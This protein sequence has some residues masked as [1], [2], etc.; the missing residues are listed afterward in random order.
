MNIYITNICNQRCPYCYAEG[1]MSKDVKK[2][3]M[4]FRDFKKVLSLL[5]RSHNNHCRFEGGEPTI[6]PEFVRFLNHAIDQGFLIQLFTNGLF[7]KTVLKALIKGGKKVYYTWNINHPSLYSKERWNLVE[8]NLA[9]ISPLKT[10]V[11]GVN[12]YRPDQNFEFIS[13]LLKK[14]GIKRLR[15]CF[16]H[17]GEIDKGIECMSTATAGRVIPRLAKFMRSLGRRGVDCGF[18]CGLIPC[19]WKD[20]DIGYFV[21]HGFHLGTCEPCPGITTDLR[22]VHCFQTSDLSHA[23]PLSCFK[24][25]DD[26][27]GYLEKYFHRYDSA[28]LFKKCPD[29]EM[30][31]MGVCT[32]GCLTERK[33][34]A[35]RRMHRPEGKS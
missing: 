12:I 28:T 15:L 2:K 9:K 22:V 33:N 25:A 21:K 3:Y 20:Q 17:R 23:K 1:M 26:I 11:L 19:Q 34:I 7:N 6:H 10:S 29:C 31:A 27:Y 4:T 18:D 24:T 35:R 13:S 5:K 14:Y 30:K 32:L 16:A 8:S